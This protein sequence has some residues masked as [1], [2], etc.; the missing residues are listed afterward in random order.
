MCRAREIPRLFLYSVILTESRGPWL[1]WWP[2]H[3]QAGVC[4]HT[5][6]QDANK[7][8]RFTLICTVNTIEWRELCI[9]WVPFKLRMWHG[10]NTVVCVCVCAHARTHTLGFC[11]LVVFIFFISF[12]FFG[13]GAKNKIANLKLLVYIIKPMVVKTFCLCIIHF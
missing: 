13:E 5:P 4:T 7:H 9:L 11:C 6:T 1:W 12:Y 8:W 2:T 10:F 3:Q